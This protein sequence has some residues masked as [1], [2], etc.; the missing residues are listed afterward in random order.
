MELFR[1]LAEL[2]SFAIAG[3]L[4]VISTL[5]GFVFIPPQQAVVEPVVQ[6]VAVQQ[7]LPE[8]SA[9][10]SEPNQSS[11]GDALRG[12]PKASPL[13]TQPTPPP[14]STPAT[15]TKSPEQVL[16][17]TRAALVNILCTTQTGTGFKPI[18]GS[19]IVVDER[20]IILTNAHVGQFFLLRDYPFKDNIQCVVRVGSPAE[21]RYT[22]E[23]LYLPPAWIE[24]NASQITSGQATGTGE[25][26][27]AFVRI[28]GTT[29]P[30]ATLPATFP[31][32]AMTLGG[33][34]VGDSMLLSG[35]PAGFL[36]GEFITT[37]LYASSAYAYVT[38]LFNFN[39]GPQVDLFSIGGTVLSQAGSSGGAAV[40]ADTGALA[41]VIVTATT[42][43]S[44]SARDLRAVSL[45]HIDRSHGEGGIDVLLSGN[46][47]VKAAAFN[48][49]VAP[50]LTK[51]LLDVLGN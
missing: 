33:T 14:A 16:A 35:Y 11:Q 25:H 46:T 17:Q 23:L 3:L 27:Y 18:S 45:G 8:A 2:V 13:V 39:G 7:E 15:P 24:A 40:R 49:G 22:A 10:E 42:A 36:S 41:G 47:A 44:T 31:R 12:L 5:V 38:Q 30:A 48:L 34:D 20:G 32:L 9:R 50:A 43:E 21:P 6:E 4:L 28:T 51:K 29:N 37:S 26:D 1:Q 19:G